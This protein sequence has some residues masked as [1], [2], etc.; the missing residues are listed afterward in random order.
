MYTNSE[1]ENPKYN[2]IA[3]QMYQNYTLIGVLP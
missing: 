2:E 3:R 1:N